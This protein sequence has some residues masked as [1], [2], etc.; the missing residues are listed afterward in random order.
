VAIEGGV[1][2]AQSSSFVPLTSLLAPNGPA[3]VPVDA[4]QP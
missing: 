2:T 3:L 1:E 4:G